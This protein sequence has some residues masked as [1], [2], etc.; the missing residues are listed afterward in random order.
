[1][2]GRVYLTA[3]TSEHIR[4][5]ILFCKD[6]EFIQMMGWGPVEPH[7]Q[8]LFLKFVSKPSLPGLLDQ[9]DFVLLSIVR[10]EDNLPIGFVSLKGIDWREKAAELAIAICDTRYRSDGYGSETLSLAVDHGFDNMKLNRISLSVF[11]FNPRAIRVYEKTGFRHVERLEK[12]WVMPDGEKV[13]LLV[14]I[15]ENKNRTPGPDSEPI[16]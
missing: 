8:A 12:A 6:R 4:K 9:S 7:D 15:A 1:M 3:A 5:Y 10:T 13:D 14:M 2:G 11:A 16:D